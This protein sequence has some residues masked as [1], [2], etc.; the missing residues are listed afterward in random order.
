MHAVLQLTLLLLFY[1][2]G[3]SGRSVSGTPSKSSPSDAESSLCGEQERRETG[4]FNGIYYVLYETT[5]PT[6]EDAPVILWLSGG[7]GCSG[8]VAALF[9]LG[10]CM[11]DDERD[12]IAANPYSWTRIAHVVFVDQP[13][14]T[15]F[16][17]S[18][19]DTP[20]WTEA[21]AMTDLVRFVDEF[22]GAHPSLATQDF[23]IFGESFGGH[24]APDLGARLLQSNPIAWQQRLKGVGIGN[25]VVSPIAYVQTYKSFAKSNA[26]ANDYLSDI[27]DQ[28]DSVQQAALDAAQ[29][30]SRQEKDTTRLVNGAHRQLRAG[31]AGGTTAVCHQAAKLMQRF[32]SMVVGAVISS[33]RNMYDL[34][35]PCHDDRLSLCYRLSRLETLVNQPE[36]LKYFG[37]EDKLWQLCSMEILCAVRD[38]DYVEESEVNVAYLLDHGVRVLVYAGDADTMAP[39][40]MH[41]QW[42]HDMTWSKRDIFRATSTQSL[43]MENRPVGTLATAG[44]LSLVRVFDAGHMVPHDQ[45]HVALEMLR[46]FVNSDHHLS[47]FT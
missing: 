30:C 4:Y 35:R 40:E 21:Q 32:T 6:R 34:R 19:N 3:G 29:S 37:V 15:G 28:L 38:I 27:S 10:P 43:T 2:L 42:T 39:W 25:G 26:Y 47:V 31:E 17:A 24:Y 7:P 45:P 5:A 33:G 44:G 16:S 1:L 12:T 11:F 14:G 46:N 41:V 13:R 18:S 20:S 22:F 36:T 23:Y 9:E 8:L